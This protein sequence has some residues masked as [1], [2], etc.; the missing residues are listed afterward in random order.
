MLVGRE[1]RGIALRT[2]LGESRGHGVEPGAPLEQAVVVDLAVRRDDLSQEIRPRLPVE[3]GAE[4]PQ[5]NTND[6]KE[7][8]GLR[9]R[10]QTGSSG[11]QRNPSLSA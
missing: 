1:A 11:I 2:D 6:H 4:R 7:H 9:H 8:D 5:M 3:H 10:P